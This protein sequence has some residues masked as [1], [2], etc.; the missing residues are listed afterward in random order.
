LHNMVPLQLE[1]VVIPSGSAKANAA[2]QS[3]VCGREFWFTVVGY[4]DEQL[5]RGRAQEVELLI[6]ESSKS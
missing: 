5:R 1:K 6:R 4:G 2:C 3:F